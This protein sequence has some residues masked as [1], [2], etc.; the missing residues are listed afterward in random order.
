MSKVPTI[1][2][3]TDVDG[4]PWPPAKRPIWQIAKE[5]RREWKNVH[6]A[7]K[8]YLEAMMDL[9]KPEDMYGADTA[10]GIISYFLSN[11][12]GWRG[13][14]AKRIKAE[15]KEMIDAAR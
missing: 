14:A 15:L 2:M 4:K 1:T 8:P 6:F 11:A 9:D 5:I 13:D 10:T 7:A 3:K 12:R